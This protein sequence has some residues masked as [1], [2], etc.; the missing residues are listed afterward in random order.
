[1]IWKWRN[2]LKIKWIQY[3]SSSKPLINPTRTSFT[4]L[5][6]KNYIKHFFYKFL[7]GCDYCKCRNVITEFSVRHF[8]I[9]FRLILVGQSKQNSY[10]YSVETYGL[11]RLT[12]H[13]VQGQCMSSRKKTEKKIKKVSIFLLN[14]MIV[15]CSEITCYYFEM[16]K[17]F[18]GKWL[19]N[20]YDFCNL[21]LVSKTLCIITFSMCCK[22][23]KSNIVTLIYIRNYKIYDYIS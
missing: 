4:N 10:L 5:S 14:W 9:L 6:E 23:L 7:Y 13:V 1:M 8:P 3:I 12:W 16:E 18:C 17:H 2:I 15:I 21:L 19:K 22:V 20:Y 11:S